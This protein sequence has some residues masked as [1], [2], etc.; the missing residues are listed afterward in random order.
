MVSAR[1]RVEDAGSRVMVSA[2]LRVED[3]EFTQ[4]VSSLMI[5]E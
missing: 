5:G 1:L 4:L 2:R 3:A